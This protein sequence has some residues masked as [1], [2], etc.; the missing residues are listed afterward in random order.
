MQIWS[1]A[2]ALPRTSEI[3][4]DL[5]LRILYGNYC[6]K[7]ACNSLHTIYIPLRTT[8]LWPQTSQLIS[9]T[10]RAGVNTSCAHVKP[11]LEHT[12][13][14]TNHPPAFDLSH[15]YMLRYI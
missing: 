12:H 6:Q 13:P 8:F 11:D 14:E 5:K 10:T 1:L 4:L 3:C 7:T 9:A 2:A 15:T